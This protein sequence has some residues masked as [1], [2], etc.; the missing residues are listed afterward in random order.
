[1]TG[2]IKAKSLRS[3]F[4]ENILADIENIKYEYKIFN[5]KLFV[6]YIWK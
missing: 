4:E 3:C 2:I 5:P 6:G 1:M